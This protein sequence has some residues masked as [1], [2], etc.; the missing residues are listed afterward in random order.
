MNY[1]VTFKILTTFSLGGKAYL[2]ETEIE[3]IISTLDRL[4][5]KALVEY[6]VKTSLEPFEAIATFYRLLNN[7]NELFV[8]Y[9]GEDGLTSIPSSW[10]A[11]GLS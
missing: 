2:G 8:P 10:T 5:D 4:D 3:R 6:G 9:R 11:R 7:K 1:F